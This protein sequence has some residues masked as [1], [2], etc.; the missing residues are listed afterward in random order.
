MY[1]GTFEQELRQLQ[2]V[3]ETLRTDTM[4]EAA[5]LQP[6]LADPVLQ[7]SLGFEMGVEPVDGQPVKDRPVS[8]SSSLSVLCLVSGTAAQFGAASHIPRPFEE[9]TQGRSPLGAA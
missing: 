4:F 6:P 7:Y 2:P 1:V 8:N 9:R 5:G 3:T